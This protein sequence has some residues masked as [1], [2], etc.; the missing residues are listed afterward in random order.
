LSNWF[1]ISSLFLAAS[2]FSSRCLM[3]WVKMWISCFPPWNKESRH[4]EFLANQHAQTVADFFSIRYS[5]SFLIEQTPQRNHIHLTSSCLHQ[6]CFFTNCERHTK[7]L[8]F[9]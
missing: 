1:A 8:Q 4:Q 2:A 7:Y 3:R 5:C 6:F 9:C